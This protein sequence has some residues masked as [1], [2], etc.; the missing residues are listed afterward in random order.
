[1]I[2]GQNPTSKKTVFFHVM[3][4]GGMTFRNI[5]SNLYRSRFKLIEDPT[6]SSIERELAENDCVE[7][8]TLPYA[9]GGMHM[10][11]CLARQNR[12]DILAGTDIFTMLR[13][14]VDQVVSQF[15]HIHMQRGIIEPVFE[16][17]GVTFPET[18]EQYVENPANFNNQLAFLVGKYGTDSNDL[19]TRQD[20]DELKSIMTRLNF[21][22]GLTERFSESVHVFEAVT[23]RFVAGGKVRNQ[24]R[25]PGR[26]ALQNVPESIKAQIRARSTFDLELYRFAGE[27]LARDLAIYGPAKQYTFVEAS[28]P[29]VPAVAEV[30]SETRN[31][32]WFPLRDSIFSFL[33]GSRV[34]TTARF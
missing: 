11:R 18:L 13:E 3:K 19:V 26:V 12:W 30:P 20:L 6:I 22:V 17:N 14:P 32:R 16:A 25:N 8:H 24:N 15:H 5:V 31:P 1:M 23:G 29:Q 21:H 27:L 2:Q 4:T 33:P 7:F 9:G 10:H 28:N 34:S